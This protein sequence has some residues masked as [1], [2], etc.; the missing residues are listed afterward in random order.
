[1]SGVLENN[2]ELDFASSL[3]K[4]EEIVKCL[5]SGDLSLEESL[6]KFEEGI[7]LARKLEMILDKADSR[8]QEILKAGEEEEN[9]HI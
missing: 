3:K 6:K 7:A 5:E 1:M 2:E 9:E 8:V 4:L